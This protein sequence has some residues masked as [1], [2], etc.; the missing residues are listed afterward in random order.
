[1]AAA[2]VGCHCKVS[3]ALS[4][5]EL[6]RVTGPL[7][8]LGLAAQ[9]EKE[10]ATPPGPSLNFFFQK[11][12]LDFFSKKKQKKEKGNKGKKRKK[13]KKR[14]PSWT[15]FCKKKKHPKK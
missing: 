9:A 3:L 11:F 5:P 8:S 14:C 6:F 15:T 1:M 10:D 7:P 4:Y 2:H 12:F 13:E